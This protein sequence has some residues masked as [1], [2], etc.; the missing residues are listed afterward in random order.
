MTIAAALM[1]AFVAAATHAATGTVITTNALAGAI[2]TNVPCGAA[3]NASADAELN[4]TAA[5]ARLVARLSCTNEQEVVA[6]LD[7]LSKLDR[8]SPET[9]AAYNRLLRRHQST[10]I[11]E[12]VLDNISL[13]DGGKLVPLLPALDYCVDYPD[14]DVREAIMD[15]LMDIEHKETITILVKRLSSRFPDVRENALLNLEVLT[16][17]DFSLRSQWQRWWEKNGKTFTFDD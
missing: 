1:T 10:P 13:I 3:T 11:M 6:A 8:G 2:A 4:R 9:L 14:E 5:V 7:L 16:G 17:E 12:A 15:I